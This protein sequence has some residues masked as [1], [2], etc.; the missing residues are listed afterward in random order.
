[1]YYKRLLWKI[2][3]LALFLSAAVFSSCSGK[4]AMTLTDADNGTRVEI[5]SGDVLAVK[6]EAQL[7]TGF[8]WKV[9]SPYKNLAPDGEPAQVSKEDRK[10]G[11]PEFQMFR[12]KAGEKGEAEL[13]LQYAQGWNKE[14]KP[15]REFTVTVIVK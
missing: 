12:F 15:R 14:T 7:G 11:G 2:P 1:M 3:L 13:K 4:P 9:V 10:P 5:K 6:L 8:G